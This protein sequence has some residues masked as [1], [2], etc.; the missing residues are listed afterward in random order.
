M[1]HV[2][3]SML[4][5]G[6]RCDNCFSARK[7]IPRFSLQDDAQTEVI[8]IDPID[9]RLVDGKGKKTPVI[10]VRF[11]YFT[12]ANMKVFLTSVEKSMALKVEF[13]VAQGFRCERVWHEHGMDLNMHNAPALKYVA[14]SQSRG[15][16][17][18]WLPEHAVPSCGDRN[19]T[20]FAR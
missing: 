12:A 5:I 14:R 10:V 6:M 8:F 7:P 3:E 20:L 2:K 13:D 19:R 11:A 16:P 15:F 4:C 17:T 9:F 1:Y 18:C